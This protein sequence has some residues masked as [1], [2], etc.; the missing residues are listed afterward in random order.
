MLVT[1]LSSQMKLKPLAEP[2]FLF[3]TSKPAP[4]SILYSLAWCLKM[5][6]VKEK[7]EV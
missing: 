3:F 5:V 4:F 6:L 2:Y 1:I 7:E